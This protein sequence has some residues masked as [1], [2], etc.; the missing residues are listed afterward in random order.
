MNSIDRRARASGPDVLI[1]DDEDD[2][3][4]LLELTLMRMGLACDGAGTVADA[5]RLLTERRYRLCLTDMRLPDGDG[6]DLVR[7]IADKVG[8]L[9]VAVITA[10]GSMDNAVTALKAGAFDYLSK[11]VSVD[12]LRAL[13]KSVFSVSPADGVEG[14]RDTSSLGGHSAAMVQVRALIEKLARSQ[15]PVLIS[16]ESGSGKERAARMIHE[17]GPR[18][19]APFVAVNCGA[20]PESL[21]ESEFFGVKRGAFTGAD[22]DREGFFQAAHGGTLF[23][24][25]VGDL[26]LPMQVKLLRAIQEKRFRRLGDTTEVGVDVRLISA[27][28]RNLKSMV[29]ASSFRQDLYYRLNVIELRMPALRERSED[30]PELATTL[31]GRLAENSGMDVPRLGPDALQA[32]VGYAFPGN[33]RELENILERALALSNGSVITA[34]DLLLEPAEELAGESPSIV[35]QDGGAPLQDYLDHV[36]RQAIVEA[37]ERAGGNRTA[38]AR[39]LGVTF[40]SLRYRLER[41]GMKDG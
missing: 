35:V 41:L 22:A 13:V 5:Q 17:L 16:G 9:P 25:E 23:L 26:P 2:I 19:G 10:F 30:I 38:A 6:L 33:V 15:A 7:F 29:E 20:I 1:V 27:T 18:S 32:L 39:A 36:E 11:P 40:R 31:L 3:R 21:M 8:D 12:Q 14:T 37:L 4:E 28:H 34:A 24:D